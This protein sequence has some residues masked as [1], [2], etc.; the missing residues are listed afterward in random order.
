MRM[1]CNA[2]DDEHDYQD[3]TS[4]EYRAGSCCP[5]CGGPSARVLTTHA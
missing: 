2:C 3:R 1:Q 5:A 4:D